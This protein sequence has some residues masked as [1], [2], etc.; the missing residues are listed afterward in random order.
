MADSV[1]NQIE[2]GFCLKKEEEMDDPRYLPCGHSHCLSCLLDYLSIQGV[3]R[4]PFC[5]YIQ[6]GLSY[7]HFFQRVF[8]K[9]SILKLNFLIYGGCIHYQQSKQVV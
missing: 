6:V 7:L 2:C 9:K 3:L 5:R 1:E 4:C 8:I